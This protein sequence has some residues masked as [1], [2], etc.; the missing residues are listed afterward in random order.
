LDGLMVET[1]FGGI[2]QAYLDGQP[3]G[4]PRDY[5]RKTKY[6]IRWISLD[7]H[8]LKA[9]AHTLKFEGTGAI[10]PE[11]RTVGPRYFSFGLTALAV[12]RLDDMAGYRA[13]LNQELERKKKEK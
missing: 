3:V 8:D 5:A 2:Y 13:I 1:Y 4:G 12:L 10:P 6:D 7:L 9:G 11:M